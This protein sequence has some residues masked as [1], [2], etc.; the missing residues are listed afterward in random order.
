MSTLKKILM[1]AV[2]II[3]VWFLV[4]NILGLIGWLL[5]ILLV[6]AAIAIIDALIPN[7]NLLGLI[8]NYIMK[9]I[10]WVQSFFRKS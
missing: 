9:F 1:W 10:D 6:I 3:A 8:G 2:I 5:P 4:T 7:S